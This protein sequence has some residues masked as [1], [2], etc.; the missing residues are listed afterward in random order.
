MAGRLT[1]IMQV[2]HY[3]DVTKQP[4][5]FCPATKT[6]TLKQDEQP[7]GPRILTIG[8]EWQRLD[9]GWIEWDKCGL[10]VIVNDGDKAVRVA[11]HAGDPFAV[12]RPGC[13][14]HCEPC[15]EW[16][17]RTIEGSTRIRVVAYPE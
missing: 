15:G 8:S 5:D 13:S 6:R 17:L 16:W 10:V 11:L 1:V 14:L 12:V 4:T 7:F 9:L 3:S 2:V